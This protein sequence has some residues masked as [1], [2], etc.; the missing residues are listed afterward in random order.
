MTA[1]T[2]QVTLV[3]TDDAAPD[4]PKYRIS[5]KV[6]HDTAL[7]TVTVTAGNTDAFDVGNV[8]I[9]SATPNMVPYLA[10]VIMTL[11]PTPISPPVAALGVVCGIT[12]CGA[13]GAKPLRAEG[14]APSTDAHAVVGVVKWS[15]IM[16]ADR[17]VTVNVFALV[18][19]EGW[20]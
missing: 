4:A 3:H 7:A 16:G 17:D 8:L 11:G 19:P 20:V 14:V 6:G 13:P 12:R 2:S 10:A 5:N 18:E 1:P 15:E 9:G